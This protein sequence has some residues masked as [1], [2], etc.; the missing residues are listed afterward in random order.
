MEEN[1]LLRKIESNDTFFYCEHTVNSHSIFS[2]E[3]QKKNCEIP[4]TKLSIWGKDV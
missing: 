3:N 2:H 4:Q 1:I